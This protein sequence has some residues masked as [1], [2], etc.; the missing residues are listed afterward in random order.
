M[1]KDASDG[2]S[3]SGYGSYCT[4]LYDEDDDDDDSSCSTSTDDDEPLVGSWSWDP[5]LT[6]TERKMELQLVD[7]ADLA[8]HVVLAV[9]MNQG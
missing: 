5:S 6:D 1:T 2:S 3:S 7:G 8:L 9:V 4:A